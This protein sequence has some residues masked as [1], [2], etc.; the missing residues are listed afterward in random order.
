[1]FNPTLVT[2]GQG[3]C[4]TQSHKGPH[5]AR[6]RVKGH[7][8][9]P[10]VP[11]RGQETADLLINLINTSHPVL[12]VRTIQDLHVERYQYTEYKDGVEIRDVEG[13]P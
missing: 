1:M 4:N 7:I 13:S 9:P 8:T 10:L 5:H 3:R 2:V 12:T 11:F 6:L